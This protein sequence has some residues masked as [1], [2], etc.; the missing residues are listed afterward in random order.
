MLVKY[1]RLFGIRHHNSL[2]FFSEW[3]QTE[4]SGIKPDGLS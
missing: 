1:N 3:H 4:L 2:K